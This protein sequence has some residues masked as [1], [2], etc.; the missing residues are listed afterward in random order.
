MFG[1]IVLIT[2]IDSIFA[3]ILFFQ[4]EGWRIAVPLIISC[5]IMLF[6][7]GGADLAYKLDSKLKN[8][9]PL[10]KSYKEDQARMLKV[11][12]KK[13]DISL[14][15]LEM[16]ALEEKILE[17]KD[18]ALEEAPYGFEVVLIKE[19]G[20]QSGDPLPVGTVGFIESYNNGTLRWTIKVVSD[21]GCIYHLTCNKDEI[22]NYYLYQ[23]NLDNKESL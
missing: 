22:Q 17:K 13:L 2:I 1:F 23:Y 12:C 9:R 5:I 3:F 8:V 19:R 7:A 15:E 6:L 21:K 16:M 11:L 10:D 20:K 18:I 4:P 14:D